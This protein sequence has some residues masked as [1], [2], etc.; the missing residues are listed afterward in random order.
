MHGKARPRPSWA[1][2]E[3]ASL[4]M[5]DVQAEHLTGLLAAT[6]PTILDHHGLTAEDADTV[7]RV[8]AEASLQA[9][10][11]LNGVVVLHGQAPLGELNVQA[12]IRVKHP[13]PPRDE[14]GGTWF[15]WVLV[16]RRLTHTHVDAA[17]EFSQLMADPSFKVAALAAGTPDELQTA[18]DHA[19]DDEVHF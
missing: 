3:Q 8:L 4:I 5:L 7:R 2:G 19:L 9:L 1:P 11:P 16:S 15:V 14:S 17:A 12:L 10:T 6:T 13:I 18:Y